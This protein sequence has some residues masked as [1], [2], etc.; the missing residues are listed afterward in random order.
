MKPG[1]LAW[2]APLA[3]LAG[4]CGEAGEITAATQVT[5]TTAVTPT[6]TTRAVA[7]TPAP[8]APIEPDDSIDCPN[9]IR[10]DEDATARRSFKDSQLTDP[11]QEL[12]AYAAGR[13]GDFGGL[14]IVRDP[15][16]IEIR[17]KSKI[18]EHCWA[19]RELLERPNTFHVI[20]TA[21]SLEDLFV[22]AEAAGAAGAHVV[23]VGG[24]VVHIRLPGSKEAVAAELHATYGDLLA[25][26]VAGW[27]YPPRFDEPSSQ[28]CTRTTEPD[29]RYSRLRVT[30]IPPEE[31]LYAISG[32]SGWGEVASSKVTIL[33]DNTGPDAVELHPTS[34]ALFGPEGPVTAFSHPLYEGG[35]S[36]RVAP[37]VG[38]AVEAVLGMAPCAL[39]NGYLLPPGTYTLQANYLGLL[40]DPVPIT[41]VAPPDDPLPP[42][43]VESTTYP[44]T[45]AAT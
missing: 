10:A 4:S 45:T 41:I 21:Y 37:G 32:Y 16:R 20:R 25:I 44:P 11:A 36:V 30:M 17:L 42:R 1:I 15:T 18:N 19:M 40:T 43:P 26:S 28:P 27:P 38:V 34:V 33:V 35:E 13:N 14:Q 39:E 5:A 3:L 9:F 7:V 23:P 24:P 12:S 2:I 6:V 8:P 29:A 31:P 22:I